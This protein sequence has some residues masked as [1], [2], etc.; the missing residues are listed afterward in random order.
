MFR[1]ALR[2]L[3]TWSFS[4]RSFP[5][6]SL[7]DL[8]HGDG[9]RGAVGAAAAALF[10]CGTLAVH[11]YFKKGQDDDESA[12]GENPDMV[13]SEEDMKARFEDWV[14]EYGRTY[15]DEEEKAMRFQVFKAN[16]KRIESLPPSYQ[17]ML[18]PGYFG[19]RKAEERPSGRSCVRFW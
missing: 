16:V 5:A 7:R 18:H 3:L 8:A 19:D 6:A 14:N 12:A 11:Q 10:G 15:R 1:R 17:K 4:P 13:T 9:R 2:S